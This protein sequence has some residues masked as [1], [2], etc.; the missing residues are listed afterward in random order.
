MPQETSLLL[1]S[2]DGSILWANAAAAKLFGYTREELCELALP[3][4]RPTPDPAATATTPPAFG[5]VA[6]AFQ[7]ILEGKSI[8]LE[9]MARFRNKSQKRIS[10]QWKL[11]K[12]PDEGNAFQALLSLSETMRLSRLGPSRYAQQHDFDNADEAIFRC[13]VDGTLMEVNG[14]LASLLGYNGPEFLRGSVSNIL[15]RLYVRPQRHTE[16]VSLLNAESTIAGFEAEVWRADGSVMWAAIFART[17]FGTQGE[18]LY[19]EGRVVDITARKRAEIALRRSEERLRKLVETTRVIPFEFE[20]TL[21]QFSYLGPQAAF[22]LGPQICTGCTLDTWEAILHPA[23][24][25]AGTQFFLGVLAGAADTQVEFRV[26]PV[27]G[28]VIWIKQFVHAGEGGETERTRGFFL[29]ITETKTLEQE[30]EH[31]NLKLRELAAHSHNVREEERTMIAREIHDELGQALTLTKI[32]LGWLN[33]RLSKTVDEEVRRPMEERVGEL[34]SLIDSTLESVRRILSALRPPLLDDL[35]LKAAIEFHMEEFSRRVGIR[36][37]LKIAGMA[38]H[39]PT[40]ATVIFRIFQEILTN[41][42]RHAKASRISVH[43]YEEGSHF[44]LNVED[45]GRGISPKD[46]RELKNFGILGMQ[47]RAWSIGGELE[48]YRRSQGGTRVILKV[49]IVS[50]LIE[51]SEAELPRLAI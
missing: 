51:A 33:G 11:S 1:L 46:V 37:D 24:I 50:P 41:V 6:T 26:I 22:L 49:P 17:V 44:Y 4:K 13:A 47:E 43:A 34:E 9:G 20:L 10:V 31:T 3:L 42:A 23:D 30:R 45:N 16:F 5:P 48:V 28:R 21:K 36:Y 8:E 14:A 29:D 7:Q 25:E 15:S 18:A 32:G 19:F 12:L 38:E 40:E 39:S 35:G 27:D 2:G